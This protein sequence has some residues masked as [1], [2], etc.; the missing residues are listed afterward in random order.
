MPWISHKAKPLLKIYSHKI[1][2]F[3]RPMLPLLGHSLI[4]IG[5]VIVY[6]RY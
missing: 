4:Q 2:A 3:Y 1:V 5:Q 6:V